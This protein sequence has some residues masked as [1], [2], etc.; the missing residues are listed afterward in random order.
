MLS[1]CLTAAVLY[2]EIFVAELQ[3]YVFKACFA[4]GERST[5]CLENPYG[6][7]TFAYRTYWIDNCVEICISTTTI[8]AKVI[9]DMVSQ[10]Q[11]VRTTYKTEEKS[12][13]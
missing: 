9:H 13:P 8:I 12:W 4:S 7:H 6:T 11:F 10:R 5:A 1:K 3:V 2:R